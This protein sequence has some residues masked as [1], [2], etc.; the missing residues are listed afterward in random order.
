MD[1]H[2]TPLLVTEHKDFAN[3]AQTKLSANDVEEMGDLNESSYS[4]SVG[5]GVA[6][7]D[8]QLDK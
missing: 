5:S 8:G 4:S 2:R 6:R 1:E 7:M 3:D